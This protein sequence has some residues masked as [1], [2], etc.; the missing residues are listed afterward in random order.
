MVIRK[1]RS[2]FLFISLVLLIILLPFLE[3]SILGSIVLLILFAVILLFGIYAVSYDIRYVATSLMLT[4]PT[5][6]V[7]WTETFQSTPELLVARFAL[8][9][10]TL[11]FI[12]ITILYHVLSVEKVTINEIYGAISVYI[13]I[14]I[15]FSQIYSLIYI[16]N[17]TSLHFTY[18]QFSFSAI[19]YFSFVTLTSVG[20]GDIIAV[21]AVARAV[22][23]VELVSGVIF[24]AVLIARLINATTRRPLKK[25]TILHEELS[26]YHE[27]ALRHTIKTRWPFFLILVFC[28]ILLNFA[29]SILVLY[30]R[31]PF[32]LDSWGTSFAVIIGS[33]WAGVLAGVLYNLIMAFTYWGISY[34]VWLFSSIL[35]A[36]LTWAFY[37]RGWVNL[38]KPLKLVTVGLTTGVLNAVLS[39]GIITAFHLPPYKGTLIIYDF[40]VSQTG[41]P[42]TASFIENLVVEIADKTISI[43]IAAIVILV[44]HSVLM[45]KKKNRFVQEEN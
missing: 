16:L 18:G 39:V 42:T 25:K 20:F 35:V 32:F 19:L 44:V 9:T 10:I 5:F 38:Y 31:V 6:I 30:I 27:I 22:V 14:A 13:L 1:R 17:P 23:T 7:I 11:F 8:S 28:A 2:F 43:I 37:K 41:N 15:T 33:L 34:W 36:V 45:N 24:V 26:S 40:F 4:V 12:L 29:T 21:T 3:D